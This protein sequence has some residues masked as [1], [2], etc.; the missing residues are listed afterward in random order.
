MSPSGPDIFLIGSLL[1][2]DS[3]I[4]LLEIGLFRSSITPVWQEVDYV[5]QEMGSFTLTCCSEYFFIVFSCP[6]EPYWSLS[7][8]SDTS[9]LRS[10]YF[11]SWLAWLESHHVVSFVFSNFSKWIHGAPAGRGGDGSCGT[12]CPDTCQ[13]RGC[14]RLQ[15]SAGQIRLVNMYSVSMKEQTFH[16]IVFS[17]TKLQSSLQKAKIIRRAQIRPWANLRESVSA[18]SLDCI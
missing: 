14:V 1:S 6:W 2:T 9:H 18:P 16:T 3:I 13:S 17:P 15:F 11:F 5:F 12:V 7:S 8:I 10:L 4:S